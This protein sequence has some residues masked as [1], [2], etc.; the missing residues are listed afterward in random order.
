MKNTGFFRVAA[1]VPSL[2]LARPLENANEIIA[3]AEDACAQGALLLL[4][5]ELSLTGYTCEDYFFTADLLIQVNESIELIRKWSSHNA[6]IVV[7]GAPFPKGGALFNAAFVIQ[8]GEVKGVVPKSVIPNSAEFYEKRWFD[9]GEQVS[10]YEEQFAP[11][12]LFDVKG[13]KFGIEICEDLWSRIP[14]HVRMAQKGVDIVLNLSASNELVGK[15]EYRSLL[16]Y[17]SAARHNI[18]YVYASSGVNE[19]SKDLVFG[20]HCIA[21]EC[22]ESLLSVTEF[23]KASRVYCVDFDLQ[24]IRHDRMKNKTLSGDFVIPEKKEIVPLKNP[25]GDIRLLSCKETLR[26]FS[27]TPFV[28]SGDALGVRAQEI[29]R[30]QVEGLSRRKRSMGVSDVV[31]GVS[32]GIDSTLALLVCAESAMA[33]GHDK[34]SIH[35]VTMPGFGTT[36]TTKDMAL[37]L[38]KLLG[39]TVH[40]ISIDAAVTQHFKDIGHDGLVHD[41]TYENSQARE[42][43]QILFDLAGK[44]NALVVG[45]GDMS[46]LALGWCTYNG[47]HMSGYNPNVSIPKTL[48]RHIIAWYGSHRVGGDLAQC[49]IES[50]RIE[51]SPE[52]LPPQDGKISQKTEEILGSYELHDFIL[53]HYLRYGRSF[54]DILVLLKGVFAEKCS[55]E[56]IVRTF[57][58]FVQR[59]STQQYKRTTLPPGPKVG[60]VSLSPRGDLRIPDEVSL[61]HLL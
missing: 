12:L 11:G 2:H 9:S 43:T 4:T 35:A 40:E 29:F 60:T 46:E 44:L 24:R 5:P 39:V 59:F 20:G 49:V 16:V 38:M 42:R 19:S 52:L 47:D 41:L 28:P 54:Q 6:M 26:K 55:E 8:D 50:S 3:L 30:I 34:S 53:W 45:T 13:V 31:I 1:S 14:P 48:V 33:M 18:G 23:N 10:S 36:S 17:S 32:G 15:G 7:V 27:P 57:E 61:R 51:V 25:V 21:S 37:S 22:G 56:E 58:I